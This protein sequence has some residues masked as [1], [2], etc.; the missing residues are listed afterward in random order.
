VFDFR[1]L[2]DALAELRLEVLDVD[3]ELVVKNFKMDAQSKIV[4]LPVDVP[5]NFRWT[6]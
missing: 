3:D 2:L 4:Q 5:E 6:P 1:P